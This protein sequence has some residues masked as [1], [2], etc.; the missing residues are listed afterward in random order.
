M[1]ASVDPNNLFG[2]PTEIDYG[3]DGA[4]DVVI[5]RDAAGQPDVVTENY[6]DAEN[7]AQLGSGTTTLAYAAGRLDSVEY[8]TTHPYLP[9]VKLDYKALEAATGRP[10]G[11][12]VTVGATN[13]LSVGYGFDP[14]GRL[15][16]VSS[17]QHGSFE[18]RFTPGS[19]ISAGYSGKATAGGA[20]VIDQTRAVD[21]QNRTSSVVTRNGSGAGAS[22][23]PTTGPRPPHP[24]PPRGR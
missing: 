10:T 21:F 17:P 3:N 6:E 11:Y 20:V 8:S 9:G 15:K 23:T 19:G 22:P 18:Y 2:E 13:H 7:T 1:L 4:P 12:D 5:A 16:T 14:Q 24:S